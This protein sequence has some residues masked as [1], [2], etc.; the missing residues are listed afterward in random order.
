MKIIEYRGSRK[1]LVRFD[2]GLERWMNWETF[3]KGCEKIKEAHIGEV[4]KNR[5][6]DI[7]KVI[8]YKNNTNVTVECNGRKIQ[9]TYRCLLRG[10]VR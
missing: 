2:N 8:D 6:G 9:C 10:N 7:C 1:V 5:W 3:D 4:I